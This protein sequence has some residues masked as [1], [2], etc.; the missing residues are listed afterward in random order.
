MHE[1]PIPIFSAAQ[2]RRLDQVAIEELEIPG[3]ELMCRAGQAALEA[4][5]ARWPGAERILVLAGAGN[6]AGDGYVIA[7]LAR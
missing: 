5:R 7:R 4:L 1:L 3:Y 6:N 2:V